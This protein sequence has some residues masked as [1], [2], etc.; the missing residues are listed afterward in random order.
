M[1]R[2]A[3]ERQ[4][5]WGMPRKHRFG[6]AWVCVR[7]HEQGHSWDLARLQ[8][9]SGSEFGGPVRGAGVGVSASFCRLRCVWPWWAARCR[10]LSFSEVD[11]AA[12]S[13]VFSGGRTFAE[14]CIDDEAEHATAEEGACGAREAE[15][16]QDEA[17]CAKDGQQECD[18]FPR[19]VFVW[20]VFLA[21]LSVVVKT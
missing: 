12:V 5:G 17:Q 2:A 8:G 11:A 10:D 6:R 3:V 13:G 18:D 7:R 16:E 21:G 14:G 1:W 9:R 4:L 19:W 15:C 20:C